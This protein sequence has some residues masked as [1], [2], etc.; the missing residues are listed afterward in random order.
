MTSN[1]TYEA[2]LAKL[3]RSNYTTM[4]IVF[5]SC[6]AV[7]IV[8]L[9]ALGFKAS[10]LAVSLLMILML[11]IFLLRE[12]LEEDQIEL[13]LKHG[14]IDRKWKVETEQKFNELAARLALALNVKPL[15]IEIVDDAG[16]F[17]YVEPR[18]SSALAITLRGARELDDKQLEFLIASALIGFPMNLLNEKYAG[19]VL[20]LPCALF[21]PFLS[22]CPKELLPLFGGIMVSLIALI[23]IFVV[24][25][26]V[27]SSKQSESKYSRI[28]SVTN[29][30]ESAKTA[31]IAQSRLTLQRMKPRT[32]EILKSGFSR[33]GIPEEELD[34]AISGVDL[35]IYKLH[36]AA[37]EL[38]LVE[39]FMDL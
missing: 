4:A 23:G 11:I 20:F 2:D 39:H 13:M 30:Y 36:K 12:Q 33:R 9:M 37:E 29:D 18:L 24:R 34:S 7:Y 32:I 35:E 38:G 19:L 8:L 22:S 3:R 26:S 10:I 28:L 17:I 25:S 5:V 1:P 15:R 31:L 14:L 6:V 21:L 27:T 16:V